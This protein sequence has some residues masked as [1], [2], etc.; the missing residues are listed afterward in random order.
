MEDASVLPVK[1]CH[2]REDGIPPIRDIL[3]DVLVSLYMY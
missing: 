1:R 2:R 3:F